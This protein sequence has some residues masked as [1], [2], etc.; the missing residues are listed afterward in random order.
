MHCRTQVALAGGIGYV[1][2]RQHKLRLG[3]LLAAA[4]ATGRLSRPGA[5][6][7]HGARALNATPEL[8]KLSEMGAPLLAAAKNAATGAVSGRIGSVSDRLRERTEALRGEP[9]RDDDDR[10][11]DEEPE[12]RRPER[13]GSGDGNGHRPRGGAQE[14][15]QEAEEYQ[16]EEEQ[17]V[18]ARR[19]PVRRR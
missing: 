4:A 12:A 9:E 7:E 3:L 13:H 14:A 6:V 17:P 5:L 16:P 18:R 8:G 15:E 19:S 10:E 1:L 2:G 11:Q